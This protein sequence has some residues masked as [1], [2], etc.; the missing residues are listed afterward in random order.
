MGKKEEK[1]ARKKAWK[2]SKW[3]VKQARKEERLAAKLARQQERVTI[4]YRSR[5]DLEKVAALL[6]DIAAGLKDG[7]ITVEHDGNEL[8]VN[9]DGVVSVT[10]R[11]R[12]THKSESV[13]VKVRWPRTEPSESETTLSVSAGA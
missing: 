8:T 13:R 7:T 11:A 12:Q 2:E 9:P 4:S 6:E 1:Q 3:Q 5:L 10:V